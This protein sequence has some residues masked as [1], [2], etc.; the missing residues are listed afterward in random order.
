MILCLWQFRKETTGTLAQGN[1]R[2][3]KE[4][5]KIYSKKTEDV[6]TSK[7]NLKLIRHGKET[8]SPTS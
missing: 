8:E 7:E 1:K 2:K 4:R 3:W 6:I 5:T